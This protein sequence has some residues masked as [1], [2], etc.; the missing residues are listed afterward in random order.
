M[1]LSSFTEGVVVNPSVED[2]LTCRVYELTRERLD[3][4]FKS[5]Q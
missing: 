1:G 2:G 5:N 4:Y 3:S